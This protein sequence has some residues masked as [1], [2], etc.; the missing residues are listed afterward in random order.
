[1]SRRVYQDARHAG[2]QR[3]FPTVTCPLCGE[4][5]PLSGRFVRQGEGGSRILSCP[6]CRGDTCLVRP[7]LRSSDRD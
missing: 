3:G 2:G 7:A 6:H 4:N 1:M 5:V